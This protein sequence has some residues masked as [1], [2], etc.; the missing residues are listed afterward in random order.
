MYQC[1]AENKHGTVY[2]SAELTVQGSFSFPYGL[3]E[4]KRVWDVLLIDHVYATLFISKAFTRVG[5]SL[6]PPFKCSCLYDGEHQLSSKV[7]FCLK[8]HK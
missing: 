3:S 4:H 8:W 7:Q 5:K 6:Y 2:A 1:V